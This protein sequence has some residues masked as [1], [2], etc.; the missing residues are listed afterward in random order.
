M[1]KNPNTVKASDKCLK[2]DVPAYYDFVHDQAL[3]LQKQF[4]LLK[5]VDMRSVLIII[6]VVL[7]E[8][9]ELLFLVLDL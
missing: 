3:K 1:T 5:D 4:F 7:W 6:F 9:K 2:S 8:I